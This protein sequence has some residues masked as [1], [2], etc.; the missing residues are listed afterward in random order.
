ML[1]FRAV[2]H[3]SLIT[4]YVSLSLNH[5]KTCPHCDGQKLCLLKAHACSHSRSV[6]PSVSLTH[7]RAQTHTQTQCS[8]HVN[9]FHFTPELQS[10]CSVLEPRG[11]TISNQP[12]RKLSGDEICF[13]SLYLWALQGFTT[14]LF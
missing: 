11:N 6:S 3:K 10:V 14:C 13:S 1:L 2:W 12:E 4:C 5:V 9:S 7:T 8:T